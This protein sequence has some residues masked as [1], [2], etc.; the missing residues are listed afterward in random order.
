MQFVWGFGR[1]ARWSS[2]NLQLCLF[3]P[4]RMISR[5]CLSQQERNAAGRYGWPIKRAAPHE[6]AVIEAYE[7]AGV[8]GEIGENQ[9]GCFRKRRQRKK[10]VCAVRSPNIST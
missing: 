3:A 4:A 1:S 8:R 10:P 5:Y 2:S 9:I 6:T 7:E